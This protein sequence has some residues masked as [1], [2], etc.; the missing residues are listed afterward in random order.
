MSIGGAA[1]MVPQDAFPAS[2][3]G[4]GCGSRATMPVRG[5]FLGLDS[6]KVEKYVG[7]M[8]R[9]MICT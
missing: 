5:A 9:Y 8:R 3:G 4:K 2:D 6:D 1:K 7:H